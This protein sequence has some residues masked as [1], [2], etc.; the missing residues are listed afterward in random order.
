[1][2]NTHHNSRS[3][4]PNES[5][6][7]KGT[8]SDSSCLPTES[9]PATAG[10]VSSTELHGQPSG[11]PSGI[12]PAAESP[13]H[14]ATGS[15]P[16]ATGGS[17]LPIIEGSGLPIVEG[18]GL[19]KVEGPGLPEVTG[20][21]QPASAAAGLTASTATQ[22]I[23]ASEAAVLYLSHAAVQK[24]APADGFESPTDPAAGVLPYVFTGISSG[25]TA[26]IPADPSDDG[27]VSD[28][29]AKPKP[30]V[31]QITSVPLSH[32]YLLNGRKLGRFI[33]NPY[34]DTA[35][36]VDSKGV[37][38]IRTGTV[39]RMV[40]PFDGVIAGEPLL[41]SNLIKAK[42]YTFPDDITPRI[43]DAA[44]KL[45]NPSCH[46]IETAKLYSFL[47]RRAGLSQ[48]DLM[49]WF[50]L[51]QSTVSNRLRLLSIDPTVLKEARANGLSERHC[52]ALLHVDGPEMQMYVMNILLTTKI[53]AQRAEQ[54][55]K[56][57]IG[58]TVSALGKTKYIDLINSAFCDIE[59][60]LSKERK[61]FISTLSREVNTLRK[62]GISASLSKFE[63][64][65]FTEIT[66]RIKK[67]DSYSSKPTFTP[68]DDVSEKP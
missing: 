37:V 34:S 48:K 13:Q 15:G 27:T 50:N 2:N 19:P 60:Y 40:R 46:F 57:L 35:D 17:G 4:E 65:E 64:D 58:K 33:V 52:R 32:L 20:P 1:M 6:G 53:G 10:G 45:S 43:V 8:L 49:S 22:E 56:P 25:N 24:T 54:L 11:S 28:E 66:I 67:D 23:S 51:S 59:G 26:A 9:C 47:I 42:V 21:G 12:A 3:S 31:C 29:S 44:L 16:S 18:S 55:V 30:Y 14:S 68:S 62:L 41:R 39:F 7:N 38:L 5:A 61:S 63:K 36:T